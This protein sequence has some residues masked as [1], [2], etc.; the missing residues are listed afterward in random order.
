M[1]ATLDRLLKDATR[2]SS[3]AGAGSSKLRAR[4]EAERDRADGAQ[5]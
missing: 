1:L 2:A 4:L 3:R 5:R